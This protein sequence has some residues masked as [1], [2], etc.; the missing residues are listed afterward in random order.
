MHFSFSSKRI[1]ELCED[2]DLALTE[3][4]HAVAEKLK[5][6]LA[7]FNAYDNVADIIVGNPTEVQGSP[8]ANYQVDLSDGFRLIFCSSHV[9]QPIN[10]G[11]IDWKRVSR[12][13][14]LKIAQDE[15]N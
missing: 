4:G 5:S 10:N 2:E 13:I 7:D 3:L 8:Y 12:I 9:K 1:R 11:N 14:I 6:R 15:S